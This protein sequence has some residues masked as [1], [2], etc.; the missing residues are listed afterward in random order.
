MIRFFRNGPWRTPVPYLC[1]V[2]YIKSNPKA[3]F[4]LELIHVWTLGAVPYTDEEFMDNFTLDSLFI[5][6]STRKAINRCMADYT[7]ASFSE[8]PSLF[9]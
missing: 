6:D 9:R 7:P 3:F 4:G 5:G 2:N 8:V 1:P